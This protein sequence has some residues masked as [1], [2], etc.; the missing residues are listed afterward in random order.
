MQRVMRRG[1]GTGPFCIH[2]VVASANDVFVKCVLHERAWV[3]RAPQAAGV[4]FVFRKQ[5]RRLPAVGVRSDGQEEFAQRLVRGP[6]QVFVFPAA[7]ARFERAS[8]VGAAPRP[9]VAK[10]KRGQQVKRGA[11]RSAIGHRESNQ[12]VVRRIFRV[13]GEHVKVTVVIENTALHQLE[14]RFV[15]AAAA[16]LFDQPRIRKFGLGIFIKRLQ[17]RM[18]RRGIEVKIAFFH[19]L[20]VIALAV[21]ESEEPLLQNRILAVPQRQRE[22]EPA[23]AVGEAEQP[24]LAPTIS[25]ATGVVVWKILPARALR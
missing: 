23:L 24:V 3:A 5:H 18:G 25:A 8:L 4:G 16:V 20:A 7:Q 19:V 21:G 9:G 15:L 10:P 22:T 14:L 13:F 1:L 17:I 2:R 11:L 6:K 12:N